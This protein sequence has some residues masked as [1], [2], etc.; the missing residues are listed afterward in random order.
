MATV[1]NLFF[2][3]NRELWFSIYNL[4]TNSEIDEVVTPV[5][6]RLCVEGVHFC[7]SNVSYLFYA[8]SD[9]FSFIFIFL[10]NF[11]TSIQVLSALHSTWMQ[12]THTSEDIIC[13]VSLEFVRRI[14]LVKHWQ[15]LWRRVLLIE[16]WVRKLHLWLDKA[17]YIIHWKKMVIDILVSPALDLFFVPRWW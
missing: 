11:P 3:W 4:S 15:Y 2:L 5:S 12:W 16:Y 7:Y 6:R 10:I 14:N 17:F 1:V 13:I 9:L 8:Q